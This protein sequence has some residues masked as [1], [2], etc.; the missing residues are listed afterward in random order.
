M[1]VFLATIGATVALLASAATVA[2]AQPA[3]PAQRGLQHA[4][5]QSMA[6]I[7]ASSGAY[8][9]DLDTGQP[10]FAQAPNTARLPASVE[11]I[12]TTS[13]ALM[14]LGPTETFTTSVL[15]IGSR[16]P[17]GVWHGT[18]YLRGGG[19]PTFGAVGFDRAWYGTGTT[20]H[21]LVAALLEA[22]GLTGVDGRIVGDE[23]YF[24]S[25][26][27]TP[28][29]GF[30]RSSDVEGELSALAYDRGF[31]DLHGNTFQSRPALVAAQAL[32]G[33]LR[34]AG[35]KLGPHFPISTG[36]T[37][38]GATVLAS[39]E[40]PTVATLI[41]LT[42]TPSD[43]YLAEMLLKDIGARLG[44]GGTTAAGAAVLRS[45]LLSKFG[46]A[47]R[48]NDGSGLSRSDSTSPAQV[49]TVLQSMATNSAFFDSLALGG[50]TGTLEHEMNGT[51]AQGN[52][53]GKTGTLHD[54]ANLAG[55]CQARDGHTLAYA[56][57]AN[58]LG[59]PDFV[60]KVEAGMAVAIAKY[61]G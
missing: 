26:R 58:R 55:Y 2:G 60:H 52:C 45:E 3:P 48:L 61:N 15:G 44:G 29:T 46:I 13:T 37:P 49:V 14:G 5:S 30:G 50:E 23:S 32:A 36:R 43:N 24:D 35:V 31:A 7:G 28:A 42:N 6:K 8:V 27:G 47:P 54:V 34:A 21:A 56:F 59:S 25:L 38:A 1:R 12:Y 40:S 41:A 18:L 22:N 53:R 51:I 17:A 9:V 19:D 57:M 20:M 16:D 33:G 11:K 10:L 4:L 39:V